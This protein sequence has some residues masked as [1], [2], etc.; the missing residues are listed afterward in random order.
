MRVCGVPDLSDMS[1]V[2]LEESLSV[3]RHAVGKDFEVS[4]PTGK[5]A[6]LHALWLEP[7]LLLRLGK[8]SSEMAGRS[9]VGA[10]SFRRRR[11]IARWRHGRLAK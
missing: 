3:F 8:G 1:P 10:R 9:I 11:G 7:F 4:I 5:L 6:G 2:V